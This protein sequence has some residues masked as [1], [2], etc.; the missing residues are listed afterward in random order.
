M[1]SYTCVKAA[2]LSD[3]HSNYPA[4]QA[5][6][7]DAMSENVDLFIFLG[8]Y[9]SD[10]AQPREVLDLL[11]RIKEKYPTICLRGNR[12][13][14][15]LQHDAGEM[16]FS[17]GSKSGS[18]LYTFQ[19]LSREDL[20]FFAQ[21][22]IYKRVEL[23]GVP[24][25]LAHA[26]K[27]DDR[28]YFDNSSN[29][30]PIFSD[31][32]DDFLL[33]GHCH[34]QYLAQKEG[35]TILNPGSVGVSQNGDRRA[36]YALLQFESGKIQPILR[37]V[38]YDL[39]AIVHAQFESGLAQMAPVWAVSILQNIIA[40]Q[41]CALEILKQMADPRDESQWRKAAENMGVK[42]SEEEILALLM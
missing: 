25:E 22:P 40:G 28:F 1:E 15:M 7:N 37:Q 30:T 13:R 6:V 38:D 36:C 34:K 42:F 5:C 2:I 35:K 21:L 20:A 10:L 26:G 24:F 23:N 14:Y 18:L 9:V 27:E 19:N 29:L 33:C 39:A 8:D 11:Y 3:I 17:E 4:F 12:E 31:M 41:E 32:A 16:A